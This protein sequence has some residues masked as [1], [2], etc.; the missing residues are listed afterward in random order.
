MPMTMTTNW[1]PEDGDITHLIER[2]EALEERNNVRFEAL[3]AFVCR[4]EY[5]SEIFRPGDNTNLKLP[6]NYS[7]RVCGEVHARD[8]LQIVNNLDI[9]VTVYDSQGRVLTTNTG[10][11]ISANTFYGLQAFEVEFLRPFGEIAKIRVYP[12]R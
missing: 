12:K 2:L 5:S 7:I 3:S 4:D 9:K 10:V 1:P 11:E 6:A 8:G